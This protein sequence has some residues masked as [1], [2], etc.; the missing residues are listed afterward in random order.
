MWIS[1]IIIQISLSQQRSIIIR[2][3]Y[4]QVT[5][6]LNVYIYDNDWIMQSLP[7][8]EFFKLTLILWVIPKKLW[9][10]YLSCRRCFP[11]TVSA[12][13]LADEF[14]LNIRFNWKIGTFGSHRFPFHPAG[15][16]LIFT[17]L[18]AHNLS[19]DLWQKLKLCI[20]KEFAIMWFETIMP[21][22]LHK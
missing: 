2:F 13:M 21:W 4:K 22:R 17:I 9:C 7:L 20:R 16:Q 8:Q 14:Y 3:N 10:D 18:I 15:M 12:P 6:W 5:T 19:S 1:W 11:W